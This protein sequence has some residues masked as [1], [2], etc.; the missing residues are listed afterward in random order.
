[1]SL[2]RSSLLLLISAV[3]GLLPA[4]Q[5][6]EEHPP[7]AAGCEKNCPILPPIS[8]VGGS[9]GGSSQN[10]DVDAGTGTLDGRVILLSDGSFAQGALFN[11]AA[12]ITADGANGTP[13]TG[14]W[15]GV[16]PFDP[17]ELDGVARVTTNWV[18]VEPDLVGGDALPTYQALQTYQI[19]SADLALVSAT[20]LD[21][22]FNAASTLRSA[23]SGQVI[24]F[25]RSA[26][27]GTPIS[28][29]HVSMT[30][31][32]AGIYASA[33]GWTLDDGNAVTNQTGLVVFA[34]V[35]PA[36]AGATRLITVTRA[37]TASTPSAAAGQFPVKVV[38]GAVSIASLG[39][40]L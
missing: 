5:K 20:T 21:A 19:T 29:L 22:V 11:Q 34:N 37:A 32:Q 10:P 24:V 30:S 2:S 8:I 14:I 4:C 17:F 28:G 13:V 38:A 23:N 3:L 39:I 31:A 15:K 6:S 33:S 1:V 35:E 18:S 12:T 36:A 7:F 40:Q 25:F 9:A 27:T 16:A 26:A